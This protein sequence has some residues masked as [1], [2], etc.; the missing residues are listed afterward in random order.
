M[1]KNYKTRIIEQLITKKLQYSGALLIE[2]PKWCGKSTTAEFFSKTIIKLQNPLILSKYIFFSTTSTVDLLAGEKPIL[3]DEWQQLPQIW[4]FIRNDIDENNLKGGYILTGSTKPK[5]N[6]VMHSGAG[7]INKILMRPM[8]LYESGE[9]SGLVSLEK[10]FTGEKINLVKSTFTIDDLTFSICRGGWPETLNLSKENSLEVVYDLFESV[11]SDEADFTD[12]INKNKNKLKQM[13]KSYARNISTYANNS[14]IYKD[15]NN[16]NHCIDNKTFEKYDEALKNIFV[17]ENVPTWPVNIRSSRVIRSKEKKQFVDPSLAVAAL[18]LSPDKLKQ[19]FEL[20]GFF[21]ESLCTR[22]LRIYAQ[23]LN[24]EVYQYHDS[25][26]LEIDNIIVLKD[27]RWA[28]VEIKLGSS[29]EEAAAENLIK[30]NNMVKQDVGAAS[31][32]M[33]LTNT[34]FGYTRKDGVIVLPIACLKH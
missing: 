19:D 5:K 25:Q 9:S 1:T 10:L 34:E 30:L 14:T 21:F 26:E 6:S 29:E 22:D 33:I 24:G 2:G 16:D 7:R 27:G 12:E 15:Q 8:S 28:A 17:I 32:L 23:S 18:S 13:I 31:F 4:D 20:L 11:I 3:F